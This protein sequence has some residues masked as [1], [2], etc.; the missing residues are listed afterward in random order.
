[1]KEGWRTLPQRIDDKLTT[2][3]FGIGLPLFLFVASLM[4]ATATDLPT[5]GLFAD[6]GLWAAALC[7]SG[8]I[9]FKVA[10]RLRKSNFGDAPPLEAWSIQDLLAHAISLL[11]GPLL[12]VWFAPRLLELRPDTWHDLYAELRVRWVDGL[13]CVLGLWLTLRPVWAVIGYITR[14]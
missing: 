6:M 7:L 10:R 2:L 9:L 1:M 14:P 11:A 13:L 12:L 4:L 3:L 5:G 8:W